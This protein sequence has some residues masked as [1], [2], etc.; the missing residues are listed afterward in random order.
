M[1]KGMIPS[2]HQLS[3]ELKQKQ[4]QLQAFRESTEASLQTM[5]DQYDWGIVSGAGHQ[6]LPL[7]TLRLDHRIALDEPYR[8]CPIFWGNFRASQGVKQNLAGPA[9]APATDPGLDQ[10][11]LVT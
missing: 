7:L 2:N 11:G 8:F 5:L 3:Q 6:G 1:E 9:V 10:S 4:L